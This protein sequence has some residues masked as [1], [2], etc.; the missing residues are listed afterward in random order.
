MR[1]LTLALFT[2]SAMAL[3][4][5]QILDSVNV[6]KDDYLVLTNFNEANFV[7]QDNSA[8]TQTF[9]ISIT[10]N[11]ENFKFDMLVFEVDEATGK[12]PVFD[13]YQ[14]AV[15]SKKWSTEC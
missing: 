9:D 15:A 7:A 6:L 1:T 13:C 14:K 8:F 2:A 4:V 12:A 5:V 11:F 3:H 10:N